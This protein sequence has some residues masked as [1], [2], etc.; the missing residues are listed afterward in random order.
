MKKLDTKTIYRKTNG[1]AS[2]S[3][4]QGVTEDVAYLKEDENCFK[5]LIEVK[6]INKSGLSDAQKAVYRMINK[7]NS[8]YVITHNF[9]IITGSNL[10][11]VIYKELKQIK[12]KDDLIK[13][14]NLLV[15]TFSGI[16]SKEEYNKV[17]TKKYTK[18]YEECEDLVYSIM[19]KKIIST[20]FCNKIQST[21][22]HTILADK[23]KS[24]KDVDI[25]LSYMDET[26]DKV[27]TEN[28]VKKLSEKIF[29][30]ELRNEFKKST[31]KNPNYT[32]CGDCQKAYA[33][34]CSKIH[35]R[36]RNICMYDYIT[37]GYQVFGEDGE[38]E[39]FIV[40]KCKNFIKD[41]VQVKKRH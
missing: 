35:D 4:E 23:V 21:Q 38:E 11:S 2:V 32:L 34:K 14:Y 17:I 30:S 24:D 33:T 27:S 13:V 25:L 8:Y 29:L 18:A 37:D 28:G 10:I 16:T 15:K 40:S 1:I 6:R 3:C 26:F 5:D 31:C 7:I 20:H 12:T 22:L 9:E 39:K 36:I 19:I 41:G